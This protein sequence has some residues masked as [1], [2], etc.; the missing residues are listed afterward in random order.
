[1][2]SKRRAWVIVGLLAAALVA[3]GM[4]AREPLWWWVMTKRVD[5]RVPFLAE[6]THV[7]GRPV[8]GFSTMRRWSPRTRHGKTVV[9]F[10]KSGM[11]CFQNEYV[12]GR[13]RRYTRWRH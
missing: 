6:V 2:K 3:L 10:L 1:M 9:Y 4:W 8:R 5:I 7:E 11:K 13:G 12:N